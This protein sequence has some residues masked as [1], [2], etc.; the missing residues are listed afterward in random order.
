MI[1]NN[2]IALINTDFIWITILEECR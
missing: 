1:V 2:Y